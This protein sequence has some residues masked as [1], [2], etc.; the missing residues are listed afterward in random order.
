M[1]TTRQPREASAAE[2]AALER[3]ERSL[4]KHLA[5]WMNA[6]RPPLPNSVHV[7]FVPAEGPQDVAGEV[8]GDAAADSAPTKIVE[9]ETSNETTDEDLRRQ[10]VDATLE[11]LETMR[12]NL[13]ALL[14]RW[15]ERLERDD[16][17]TDEDG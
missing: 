7:V 10:V 15:R 16:D 6:V 9:D 3:E 14:L 5:W 12:R 1:T 11:N 8:R 2:R 17:P 4:Q 13:D